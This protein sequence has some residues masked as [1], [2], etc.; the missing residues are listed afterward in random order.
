[1]SYRIYAEVGDKYYFCGFSSS[2]PET[3]KSTQ[4]EC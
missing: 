3:S 1:M 2:R 4:T